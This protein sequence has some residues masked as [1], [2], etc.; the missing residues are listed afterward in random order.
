M[1]EEILLELPIRCSTLRRIRSVWEWCKY[2]LEGIFAWVIILLMCVVLQIAGLA[3]TALMLSIGHNDYSSL[4]LP[5]YIVSYQ[6][7]GYISLILCSVI[8]FMIGIGIGF[9]EMNVRIKC[10]ED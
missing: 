10:V 7:A 3:F 4:S 8:E 6:Y 2:I 5:Y 9:E 1:S